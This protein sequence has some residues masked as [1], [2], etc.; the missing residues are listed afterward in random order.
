MTLE[1][2]SFP[3]PETRFFRADGFVYKFKIRGGSS[4]SGEEVMEGNCFNQELEDIIRTV[5]GNLDNL[6]PFSSTHFNVFPYKK[7]WEG[8]SKVM[9]KHDEKNLSAYPFILILYLEKNTQNGKHAEK[10]LSPGKERE[11]HFS[12]S[13]PQS[14][15]TKTDSPLEEAILQD[16]VKELE[17]ESKISMVG[18]HVDNPHEEGEVKEDPGHVVKASVQMSPCVTSH[19]CLL[20]LPVMSLLLLFSSIGWSYDGLTPG[21]HLHPFNV[22]IRSDRRSTCKGTHLV[23]ACVGYCESSAF[24]SRYSVLVASNFTHNITSA[25]RCC[26]ISKDAKVKVRLDCPRGRHHDEI[27]ILTAKAC[28]CDMCRKSRY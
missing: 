16:L 7:R 22:T 10:R 17:A 24:P 15:R 11:H 19:L 20:V 28:R 4:F 25:S 8:L 1:T 27:E 12:V 23:Y 5:L 13:K 2:F 18:L 9:C 3:L 26:T 14:K 6:Q 21:C